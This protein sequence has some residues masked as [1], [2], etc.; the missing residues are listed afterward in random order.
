MLFL[1]ILEVKLVGP[2]DV[3][4]DAVEAEQQYRLADF[5]P[6]KVTNKIPNKYTERNN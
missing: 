5:T 2:L 4:A 6:K 3:L 1:V